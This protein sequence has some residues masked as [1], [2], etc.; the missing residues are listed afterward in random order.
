MLVDD[1]LPNSALLTV[2]GWS[3]TSVDV[4]S[5]C[6][7]EAVSQYLLEGTLPAEGTICSADFGPFELPDEPPRRRY[8]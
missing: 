1:L 2:G 8:L 3:H 4:P 7:V 5:E 6:T